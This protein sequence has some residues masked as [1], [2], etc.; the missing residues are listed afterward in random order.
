MVEG[1]LEGAE[2]HPDLAAHAKGEA[3]QL[4]TALLD[5]ATA[6]GEPQLRP[7]VTESNLDAEPPTVVVQ[8]CMDNTHWVLEG[9]DPLDPQERNT[10]L[11]IA[12]VT[13]ED[14]TWKVDDLWAGEYDA[15]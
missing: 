3:L 15:C 14:G 4:T 1:S 9:A 11:F 6:T 7:E 8:D 10:R 12:T 2:D 5:G 13:E